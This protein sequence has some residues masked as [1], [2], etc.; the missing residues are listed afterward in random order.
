MGSSL[1]S[2]PTRDRVLCKKDDEAVPEGTSR[3]ALIA[4]Y[5]RPAARGVQHVD[6]E[7]SLRCLAYRAENE[8]PTDSGLHAFCFRD[9]GLEAVRRW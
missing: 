2:P 8:R 5:G 9:G 6:G 1:G 4:Q 7:P 3:D